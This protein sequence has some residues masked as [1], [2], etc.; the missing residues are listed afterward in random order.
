MAKK[1]KGQLKLKLG[2]NDERVP[3]LMGVLSL[4]FALYLFIAF[5]SYLFTWKIDQDKVFDFSWELLRTDL[6]MANWLGRLGAIV[7]NMFFYWGFGL[8]SYFLIAILVVWG[9]ALI[10]RQ[11]VSQH[12]PRFRLWLLLMLVFSVFLEF[13]S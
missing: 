10:R 12:R 1:K 3:K 5:T 7:S 9:L 4:F 13:D 11:P 2:I 6:E 8:P